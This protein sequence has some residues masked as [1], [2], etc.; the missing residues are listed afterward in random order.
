[1]KK[2]SLILAL[3]VVAVLVFALPVLAISSV[4][5]V[6]VT[7]STGT[8]GTSNITLNWEPVTVTYTAKYNV[9]KSVDGGITYTTLSTSQT[10]LT[11]TDTNVTNYTNVTYKVVAQEWNGASLVATSTDKLTNV[12]PPDTNAHANF[13]TN[14]NVCQQCH[15]THTAQ[16]A[17]LLQASSTLALCQTC[18][19]GASTNSKYNVKDGETKTGTG[20]APSLGGPMDHTAAVGDQWSNKSSSS[21]HTYD[22]SAVEAPGGYSAT[23]SLTCTSC[24]GAHETGNYRQIK[25]KISYPSGPAGQVTEA[26]VSVTA[27]AAAPNS[28]TGETASYLSGSVSLCSAC[29]GDYNAAQGS[30]ETT[31]GTYAQAYRHPVNVAPASYTDASGNP[32]PLTTGLPLEGNNSGAN[33]NQNK[34]VC[35]TCHFAHGTVATGTASSSVTGNPASTMLKRMD[36]MGVCEDCHKK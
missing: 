3:V 7:I 28:N 27:A 18:H 19:W 5:K 35:L 8:P 26:T 13:A 15:Q 23:Q 12:Y 2:L 31:S 32:A 36:N 29:H 16:G 25:N 4:A 34:V 10:G 6:Q 24:H 33:A 11:Y 21:W 14:T 9:A 20:Y 30:G 1:M 17:K 22:G